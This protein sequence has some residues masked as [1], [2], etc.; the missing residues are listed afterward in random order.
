[1]KRKVYSN[2]KAIS[3]VWDSL[4]YVGL[5]GIPEI[6]ERNDVKKVSALVVYSL[7]MA[8]KKNESKP[9][10]LFL[11]SVLGTE[12]EDYLQLPIK[13]VQ[14]I[15]ESFFTAIGSQQRSLI[16][17]HL[18]ELKLQRDLAMKKAQIE[19]RK[20]LLDQMKKQEKSTEKNT[21]E[22]SLQG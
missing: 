9:M 21:S 15:A 6:K 10:N 22:E 20:I 8:S 17:Q 18:Y 13:E 16:K 5:I 19:T 1:M 11:N 2:M 7:V 12:D 3:G 4:S 14:S